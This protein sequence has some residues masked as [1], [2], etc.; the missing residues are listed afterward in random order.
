MC[1]CGPRAVLRDP[2]L[3]LSRAQSAFLPVS[4]CNLPVAS[5][6]F[7][8]PASPAISPTKHGLFPD[9]SPA[10]LATTAEGGKVL[11]K[12]PASVNGDQVGDARRRFA[13]S[14]RSFYPPSR[15]DSAGFAISLRHFTELRVLDAVGPRPQPLL[16]HSKRT[17]DRRSCCCGRGG[18]P[19]HGGPVRGSSELGLGING[20]ANAPRTPCLQHA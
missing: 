13:L 16:L 20:V 19:T 14:T 2:S 4:P 12:E 17:Q 11:P 7:D 6:P 10:L 15:V 3:R 8:H 1:F 5:P 18:I 9:S